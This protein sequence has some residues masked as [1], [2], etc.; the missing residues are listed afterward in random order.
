MI[1]IDDSD[2]AFLLIRPHGA[3]SEADVTQVGQAIDDRINAADRVPNLVVQL[4][5]VPHWD[6]LSA[7]SRHFQL[8]REHHKL[9]RRIAVVGDG[10]LIA[11][12][13]EIANLVVEATVRRFPEAKLED[14]KAWAGSDSEPEGR[15]E[16]IDGLPA[17]VIALRAIGLITGQAYREILGPMIEERLKRHDKVKLLI[18]LDDAYTGLTADARL[19][20]LQ[21]GLAHLRDIARAALVTDIGWMTRAT[22]LF[23][24]LVPYPMRA[25]GMDELEEAKAW[26]KT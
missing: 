11:L 8:V 10:A 14:A 9:I 22:R 13:P 5:R 17:D 18:V 6:S 7:M 16:P 1:T 4:D 26:I 21:L 15:F 25:F 2:P 3:L 12:A 20:D 24:P 23:T 19:P